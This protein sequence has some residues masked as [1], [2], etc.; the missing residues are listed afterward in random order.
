MQRWLPF[1]GSVCLL[2]PHAGASD[3]SP[4]AHEQLLAAIPNPLRRR[5]SLAA[6]ELARAALREWDVTPAGIG[7]LGDGSPA[8]P[9]GWVGS[10]AHDAEYAIALVGSIRDYAALAVD[11]EPLL[12][13][14]EDAA[15]L[16]IS[17][18]ERAQIESLPGGWPR[19]S[20]ALFGAKECVHKALN[21]LTGVFL[22]FD[23]VEI[24]FDQASPSFRAI[25]LSTAASDVVHL[26]G[27]VWFTEASVVSAAAIRTGRI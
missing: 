17:A 11:V 26:E 6:R 4:Y 22:D 3:Y 19:W 23:E 10:L 2:A 16:V 13:L 14:P 18:R 1:A 7:R 5:Q 12:P 20:R 8:W 25:A 15:R 9:R 24:S 21:P 27:R